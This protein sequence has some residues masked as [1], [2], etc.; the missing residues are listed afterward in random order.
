MPREW[1]TPLR[2][3]WN[4]LIHQLLQAIDRHNG[5]YFATGELWHLRKAEQLRQYVGEV[6][7][8]I[9]RHERAGADEPPGPRRRM[10]RDAAAGA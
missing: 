3:P 4:P 5:L 6:K 10:D 7:E 8:W 1:N 2:E 9:G